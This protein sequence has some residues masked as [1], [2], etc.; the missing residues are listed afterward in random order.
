VQIDLAA[1]VGII[2]LAAAAPIVADLV[3]R[4]APPLVVVEIVLGILARPSALDLVHVRRSP[5]CSRSSASPS[6]SSW[7]PRP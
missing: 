3:P 7:A 2:A 6:S 1:L 5:T 4:T